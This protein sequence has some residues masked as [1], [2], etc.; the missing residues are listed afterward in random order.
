MLDC[1]EGGKIL[2]LMETE[3]KTVVH[4]RALTFSACFKLKTLHTFVQ[5]H[6]STLF[7]TDKLLTKLYVSSN[8]AMTYRTI[9][10]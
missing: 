1:N 8:H 10:R 3:Q 2:K 9:G 7:S 5:Q 4:Y 6:F